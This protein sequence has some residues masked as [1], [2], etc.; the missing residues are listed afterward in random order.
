MLQAHRFGKSLLKTRA[1]WDQCNPINYIQLYTKVMTNLLSQITLA[2]PASPAQ[3]HPALPETLYQKIQFA[4]FQSPLPR[5]H[6]EEAS[7]CVCCAGHGETP[8]V[9]G[10]LYLPQSSHDTCSSSVHTF[11]CSLSDCL[12]RLISLCKPF[13]FGLCLFPAC[14]FDMILTW[15]CLLCGFDTV[16][17]IFFCTSILQ[18]NLVK[19]DPAKEDVFK[20]HLHELEQT[21]SSL[22]PGVQTFSEQLQELMLQFNK[23]MSRLGCT[24]PVPSPDLSAHWQEP[25][26]LAIERYGDTPDTCHC[27]L[28][29]ELQPITFSMENM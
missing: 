22:W 3:T 15:F 21:L 20:K 26:R 18:Y 5:A 14:S 6:H 17:W 9:S 29:F 27:L 13:N 2:F 7:E 25:Q 16:T 24:T 12:V 19:M 10:L 23:I 28:T 11:L 4:H 8:V 1:K